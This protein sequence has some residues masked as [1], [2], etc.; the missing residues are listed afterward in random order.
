MTSGVRVSVIVVN[1]NGLRHLGPCLESLRQQEFPRDEYEVFVVDNASTDGS[2]DL[3]RSKYG[4]VRLLAQPS[5][6][7][8]AGG[9]NVGIRAARGEFV[10][11]LNNDAIAARDWLQQL[12]G[13]S[14]QAPDIG[15]VASKILF[16]HDPM[17]LNSAG[18]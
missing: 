12:V 11:L 5:N 18:L 4:W 13:A 3:M 8:F 10:A 14:H 1:F 17:I 7:G 9:C 6:L 15:G 16:Q 2:T